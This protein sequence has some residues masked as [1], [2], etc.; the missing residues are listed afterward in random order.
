MTVIIIIITIIINTDPVHS[1][2]QMKSKFS[3]VW[4]HLPIKAAM[5]Y[6]VPCHTQELIK[7]NIVPRIPECLKISYLE[8]DQTSK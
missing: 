4:A 3:Q 2:A 6:L 5:L 8:A 1:S 7:W